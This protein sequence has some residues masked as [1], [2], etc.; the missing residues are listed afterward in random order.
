MEQWYSYNTNPRGGAGPP[1][2]QD[3][4]L[5]LDTRPKFLK[6]IMRRLGLDMTRKVEYRE[7]A[8]ILKPCRPQNA[9]RAF[10]QNLGQNRT[11]DVKQMRRNFE[12]RVRDAQN[13][14]QP[15]PSG[16]GPLK[17]FKSIMI[18]RKSP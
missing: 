6:A 18:S 13:R 1:G 17:A 3:G 9:L 2:V 15:G 11:K 12:R 5:Y 10:G 8:R 4:G 16:L 14:P 7:F